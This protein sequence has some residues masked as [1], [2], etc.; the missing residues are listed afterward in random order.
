MISLVPVGCGKEFPKMPIE[1]R[2]IKLY[3]LNHQGC[4]KQGISIDKGLVK[5]QWNAPG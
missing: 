1:T 2:P 5:R 3:Y 4:E